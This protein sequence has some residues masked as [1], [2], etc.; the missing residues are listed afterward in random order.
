[1]DQ[2]FPLHFCIL[3]AIK[4]WTVGTKLWYTCYLTHV[5]LWSPPLDRANSF[6]GTAEYVSPE[7]LQSKVAYKR[8]CGVTTPPP[9]R[10]EEDWAE[11]IGSY[12]METILYPSI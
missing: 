7:L 2:G 10:G 8:Y 12:S 1:M 6:V 5:M 3:Q 4:N 11:N 9:K